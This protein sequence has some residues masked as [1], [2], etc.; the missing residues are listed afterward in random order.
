[1]IQSNLP[2]ICFIRAVAL[3]LIASLHLTAMAQAPN[4][5]PESQNQLTSSANR[6]ATPIK[7][8]PERGSPMELLPKI[9]LQPLTD[10]DM[11]NAFAI[12]YA[13]EKPP[14][15]WDRIK[16]KVCLTKFWQKKPTNDEN[17]FMINSYEGRSGFV[18]INGYVAR[19]S[20][21]TS[22]K[23]GNL[24]DYGKGQLD[25]FSIAPI[26]EKFQA[27]NPK[28]R[29]VTLD[30][31]KTSEKSCSLFDFK[32]KIYSAEAYLYW[33]GFLDEDYKASQ[34]PREDLR[35][36]YIEDHCYKNEFK[37][38]LFYHRFQP[39]ILERIVGFFFSLS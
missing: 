39:N 3:A 35:N 12:I 7:T 17:P 11:R 32:C 37:T 31:R 5:Q 13:K 20:P 38:Q 34:G 27:M 26:Q 22:S 14:I 30:L 29:Y 8:W 21:G 9:E 28:D 15:T 23:L 24:D 33:G 6:I 2:S 25:A 19:S 16:Q 4:K 1:M 10:E 18:K 36:V